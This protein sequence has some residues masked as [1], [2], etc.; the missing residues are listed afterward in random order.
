LRIAIKTAIF[1]FGDNYVNQ[2]RIKWVHKHL[3][4][5]CI[6][7]SEVYHTWDC[8]EAFRIMESG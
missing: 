7:A 1:D 6:V 3:C 8:E 5:S 2:P 4:Q